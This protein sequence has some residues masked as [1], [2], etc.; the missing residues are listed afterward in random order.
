MSR[1]DTLQTALISTG[2]GAPRLLLEEKLS[3]VARLMRCAAGTC[4]CCKANAKLHPGNT[5][6]APAGHLLLKEKAFGAAAPVCCTKGV[7]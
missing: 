3:S 7:P 1:A 4:F 5:S 6:S 2:A